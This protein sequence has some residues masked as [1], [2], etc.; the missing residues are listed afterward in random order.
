ME[1]NRCW[2]RRELKILFDTSFLM[3]IAIKPIKKIEM[4]EE[5]NAEHIILSAVIHEL[6]KLQQSKEVKRA[7]AAKTALS[8]IDI[9]KAKVIDAKGKSIDDLII[10]Y[11]KTNN[12]YVATIDSEMRRKLREEGVGIITLS[13]DRII[14]E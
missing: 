8:M 13:R 11:A 6:T 14:F 2:H 1:T 9:I 4:L 3:A 7:K 10:D 5:L 12:A